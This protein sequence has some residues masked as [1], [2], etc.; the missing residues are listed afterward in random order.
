MGA[1]MG[2]VFSTPA[3]L[4]TLFALGIEA[5]VGLILSASNGLSEIHKDVLVSFTVAFP[6]VILCILWVLLVRA[7]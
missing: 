3:G 7:E 6:V 4:L 1:F 2:Y 5:V